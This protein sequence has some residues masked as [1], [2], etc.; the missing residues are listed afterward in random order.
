M[1]INLF[2]II[3]PS[4]CFPYFYS[5]KFLPTFLPSVSTTLL[6]RAFSNFC[7]AFY[8]LVTD[9]ACFC[10]SCIVKADCVNFVFY[11]RPTSLSMTSSSTHVP[12][13]Y[14]IWFLLLL[15]IPLRV[16]MCAHTRMWV[17]VKYS[18][19]FLCL[20]TSW[21]S[22]YLWYYK[23]WCSKHSIVCS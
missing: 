3:Y 13:N 19:P 4:Y 7:S 15:I 8:F 2:H 11:S 23:Y 14:I 20:W 22:F 21:R 17:C 5:S 12:E 10:F 18:N 9:Y 16:C 6:L 1:K